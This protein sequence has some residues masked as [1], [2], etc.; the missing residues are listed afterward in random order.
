MAGPYADLSDDELVQE[1]RDTRAAISAAA[2]GGG[3]TEVAGEGRRMVSA[4]TNVSVAE[5]QLRELTA[6]RDRRPSLNP[7]GSCGSAITVWIG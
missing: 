4:A 1:I 3:I 2:K 7:S 6:E 5:R